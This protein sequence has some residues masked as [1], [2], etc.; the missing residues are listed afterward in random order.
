[1]SSEWTV[2]RGGGSRASSRPASGSLHMSASFSQPI[3]AAHLAAASARGPRGGG[4]GGYESDEN[5]S[6]DDE[7]MQRV[8]QADSRRAPP[9][10]QQQA[11]AAKRCVE[12]STLPFFEPAWPAFVFR[13]QPRKCSSFRL[14]VRLHAHESPQ[15]QARR[16][17]TQ[18]NAV[19]KAAHCQSQAGRAQ[20]HA[21]RCE[22]VAAAAAA[23]RKPHAQRQGGRAVGPFAPIASGR[24]LAATPVAAAAKGTAVHCGRHARRP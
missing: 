20:P 18:P 6:L 7:D 13:I 19:G 15:Q 23:D 9:P 16:R 10:Q 3:P 21:G 8:L 17:Q 11:A 22:V 4:G 1:M 14:L 2:E 12:A 24:R 5:D